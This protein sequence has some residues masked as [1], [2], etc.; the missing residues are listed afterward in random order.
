M[1]G[2]KKKVQNVR[3]KNVLCQKK[4]KKKNL[5]VT[6]F[7]HNTIQKKKKEKAACKTSH[8][9][10]QILLLVHDTLFNKPTKA[11]HG[12]LNNSNNFF[13]FYLS[14]MYVNFLLR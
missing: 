2:P 13:V 12:I 4:K 6:T 8:T 9:S 14:C 3:T 7:Q 1:Y 5:Q 10:P 11:K